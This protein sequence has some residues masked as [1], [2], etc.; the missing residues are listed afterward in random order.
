M[1][2]T[3]MEDVFG[4]LAERL[5]K[6]PL[7]RMSLSAAGRLVRVCRAARAGAADAFEGLRVRECARR[8]CVAR[9]RRVL[10]LA[11]PFLED[12]AVVAGVQWPIAIRIRVDVTFN[13]RIRIREDDDLGRCVTAYITPRQEEPVAGR[14]LTVHRGVVRRTL[15]LNGSTFTDLEGLLGALRH[16]TILGRTRWRQ[17]HPKEWTAWTHYISNQSNVVHYD[18]ACVF[19]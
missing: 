1:M 13:G 15:S 16:T 11:N 6:G 4:C 7:W 5:T 14:T 2:T 8:M 10:A 3:R 18:G 9:A 19:H 12:C 17:A